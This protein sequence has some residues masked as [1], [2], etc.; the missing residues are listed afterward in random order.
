[1]DG[2]RCGIQSR[3]KETLPPHLKENVLLIMSSISLLILRKWFIIIFTKIPIK[4][5]K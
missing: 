4:P 3:P 2:K 1:M 5:L